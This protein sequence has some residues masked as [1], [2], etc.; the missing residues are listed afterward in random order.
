VY[1]E[2][3]EGEV[4]RSRASSV[5][6]A[7]VLCGIALFAGRLLPG[8]QF[9]FLQKGKNQPAINCWSSLDRF[10][11]TTLQLKQAAPPPGGS[12]CPIQPISATA[13]QIVIQ[14]SSIAGLASGGA[15]KANAPWVAQAPAA[16]DPAHVASSIGQQTKDTGLQQAEVETQTPASPPAN[17][18]QA[19]NLTNCRARG[20]D[21]IETGIGGSASTIQGTIQSIAD[22]W[23][24]LKTS[25]QAQVQKYKLLS[26]LKITIGACS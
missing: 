12:A 9:T 15:P 24:Y 25:G 3:S 26:I 1:V 19:V 11:G 7:A 2:N 5:R 18:P 21:S 20:S 6:Y 13:W 8:Q 10:D 17:Q 16:I 22:G 23:V 4:R 14:F